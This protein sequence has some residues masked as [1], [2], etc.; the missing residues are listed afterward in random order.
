[1]IFITWCN[2]TKEYKIFDEYMDGFIPQ[3]ILDIKKEEF[4]SAKINDNA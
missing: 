3:L 2:P 4:S 1:M